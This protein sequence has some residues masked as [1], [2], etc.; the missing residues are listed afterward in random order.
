MGPSGQLE[1]PSHDENMMTAEDMTKNISKVVK[2][3]NSKIKPEPR[4]P[5]ENGNEVVRA[6]RTA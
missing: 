1:T 5:D 2:A 3:I 4:E 6:T